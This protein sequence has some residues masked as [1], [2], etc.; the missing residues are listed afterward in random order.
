MRSKFTWKSTGLISRRKILK[1]ADS[2]KTEE[3]GDDTTVGREITEW[4]NADT[5]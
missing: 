3:P 2:T 4:T 1:V 5:H